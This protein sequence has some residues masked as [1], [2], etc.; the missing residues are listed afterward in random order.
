MLQIAN[1]ANYPATM[2]K[3]T[4]VSGLRVYPPGATTAAYVAFSSPQQACSTSVHQL[5]VEAIA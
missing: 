3:P 2:C 1:Y 4:T 5:S